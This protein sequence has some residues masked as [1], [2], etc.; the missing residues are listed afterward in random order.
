MVHKMRIL[1][2]AENSWRYCSDSCMLT[3]EN[4]ISS[5][6]SIHPYSREAVRRLAS[7]AA[8]KDPA[9]AG[10]RKGTAS[11]N[12]APKV[13]RTAR[14]I[15]RPRAKKSNVKT[16]NN[17]R[18][19][20]E[21]PPNDRTSEAV[22]RS[23]G[24]G[25]S[26]NNGD[27]SQDKDRVN[28]KEEVNVEAVSS[29]QTTTAVESKAPVIEGRPP[30]TEEVM[31]P[32]QSCRP[33]DKRI[34]EKES[35][36][37]QEPAK[38]TCSYTSAERGTSTPDPLAAP[39]LPR[40]STLDLVD[41]VSRAP[42]GVSIPP[43][44]STAT[45][46]PPP[47]T[48][49]PPSTL[50]MGLLGLGDLGHGRA[51]VTRTSPAS[52]QSALGT[53]VAEVV[54]R[55][56]DPTAYAQTVPVTDASAG[57]GLLREDDRGHAKV[58]SAPPAAKENNGE[59]DKGDEEPRQEGGGAG[60]AREAREKGRP[61][62]RVSFAEGTKEGPSSSPG[63]NVGRRGRQLGRRKAADQDRASKGEPRG[64]R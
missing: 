28:E 49:S 34:Q 7:P 44:T 30:E 3:T 43:P 21:P 52:L 26:G 18:G 63:S 17:A 46:T 61:R 48:S 10:G 23:N 35:Q 32:A 1:D 25:P 8:S 20:V 37:Q 36:A 40:I 15:D 45:Q 14:R 6:S 41:D 31:P 39:T 56:G 5:L 50:S 9:E 51:G 53:A 13:H 2:R 29:S 47:S 55:L 16:V 59:G 11:A 54:G 62:R 60:C 19:V 4:F 12:S 58:T 24:V 33:E 22:E 38:E 42:Q 27:G 64:R 57:S